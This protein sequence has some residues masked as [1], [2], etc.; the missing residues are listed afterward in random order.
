MSLDFTLIEKDPEEE[1][2]TGIYIRENGR[3][4]EIS[5]EEWEEKFP[6]SEPVQFMPPEN[7]EVFETNIT[8]N[9]STMA[10]KAGI[11]ECLWDAKENGYKKAEDVIGPL[12]R[13]IERLENN[14]SYFKEFNASNGWGT[15]ESFLRFVYGV[16]RACKEYPEAEIE[17][18]K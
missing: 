4:R 2:S 15:Y 17:I 9:V 14:P 16:L 8:H 1:N 6:G 18:S 12:E 10:A 3:T 11:R 7:D 13:G 5:Q